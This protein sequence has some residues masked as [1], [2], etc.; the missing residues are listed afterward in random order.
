[1][2]QSLPV[3]LTLDSWVQQHITTLYSAK[4]ADDF[5]TAFDAFISNNVTIK[6]N[7]KSMTRDQYKTLIMGEIKNDDGANVAFN[8][9]VAVLDNTE[10]FRPTFTGT[11]GVFFKATVLGRIF[12]LGQR[13]TSTVTSSLNVV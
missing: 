4:T 8:G 12:T 5:N 7:G 10:S 2:S 3:L 13:Q 11:A 9:T 1:M 6:V